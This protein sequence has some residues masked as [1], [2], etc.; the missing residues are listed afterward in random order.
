MDKYD[1]ESILNDDPLWLLEIKHKSVAMNTD[2]RLLRSFEEIN[3]FYE[4]NNRLPEK[5]TGNERSLHVRLQGILDN[6][7]KVE[8]LKKHDKFNLLKDIKEPIKE[9][10][11]IDDIF[12][13]D[14]LWIFDNDEENIH[15]LINVPEVDLT[16]NSPDS[17]AHRKKCSNFEQY[18]HLFEK[19]H[20]DLKEWRRKFYPY[21]ETKLE[22]WMFCVHKWI[23]LLIA[24]IEKPKIWENHRNN[25]RTLLIF[26]NWT[27]SNMLLRSLRRRLWEWWKMIT[28]I[29]DEEETL[30][31]TISKED[32]E[33]GYIYILKS[34]SKD[35][36]ILTKKDLYKIWFSTTP[37]EERIKDAVNDP[38]Y[39]MAPVKIVETFQC[40]NV[41]PHKLEQLIH[42]FFSQVCLDL[43]IID[44]EWNRN[45]PREWFTVP[46]WVIEQAIDLIISWEIVKYRYN[47]ENEELIAK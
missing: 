35:D 21:D 41:N 38:T 2:E 11:S 18:E 34:L 39:L 13:A 4:K 8:A 1:L 6:P 31:N 47:V 9:A 15:K 37:V 19:C 28:P 7:K 16:R 5:T 30:F 32:E 14:N 10:N 45:R 25:W 23:M 40:Y 43:D 27:E 12:A 44:R 46:L 42:K 22:E 36:R 3:N 33:S 26:E 29:L 17:V 24:K 20:Q